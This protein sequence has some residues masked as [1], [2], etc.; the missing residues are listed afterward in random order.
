MS[1][2]LD[3]SKMSRRFERRYISIAEPAEIIGCYEKTVYNGGGGTDKLTKVRNGRRQV[4]FLLDAF[5]VGQS[6][7]SY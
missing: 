4:R 1:P 2:V 7:S 6:R 5:A 3:A